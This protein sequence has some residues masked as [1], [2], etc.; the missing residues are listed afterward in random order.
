[1]AYRAA[2]MQ[3]MLEEA[4][5]FAD[6]LNLPTVRPIQ[7]TDIKYPF[8]AQPW[9]SIIRDDST[10][11][12]VI[13]S[14]FGTNIFNSNIPRE[15]RLRS[16]EIGALG[17]IETTNFEFDFYDGRLREAMR[18]SEHRVEYYAHDLE[19]LVGKPSLIDTNGAYQLAI[20]WLAAVDVDMAALAKLKWTVNQLHYLPKGATNAVTLPLYYVDFGSKHHPASHNL[21][22]FDQPLISV[23]VLGTTKQLQDLII[24]DLTFSRRPLL[25][26]TNALELIQMSNPPLKHFES[27]FAPEINSISNHRE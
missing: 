25:L 23:E 4:N 10:V 12:N 6:R 18:L 22:A 11:P 24:N 15:Q 2:M 16:L 3:K 26:I 5:Y 13:V 19:T 17:T 9:F 20:Q 21:K 1:M 8:V 27:S 14:R 7:I